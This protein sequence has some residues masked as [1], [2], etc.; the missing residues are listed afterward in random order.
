MFFLF[1]VK[2]RG[3]QPAATCKGNILIRRETKDERREKI[4][5][6]AKSLPALS[7]TV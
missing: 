6:R 4:V 7:M 3:R 5:V 2:N 1:D